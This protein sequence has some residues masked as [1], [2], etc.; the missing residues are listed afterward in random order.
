MS[1]SKRIQFVVLLS[2]I[3]LFAVLTK[4]RG[5]AGRTKISEAWIR[6]S[7]PSF[8]DAENTI[9][10]EHVYRGLP[11][12]S[13]IHVRNGYVIS[14]DAARRVGVTL[15]GL[16]CKPPCRLLRNLDCK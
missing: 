16:S 13:N 12:T 4:P 2:V 7:Q 3:M 10:T 6:I 14:Y 15:G 8:T 11:G 5:S 9:V 1:G